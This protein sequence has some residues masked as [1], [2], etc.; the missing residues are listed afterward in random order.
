MTIDAPGSQFEHCAVGPPNDADSAH[1]TDEDDNGVNERTNA[2]T[3]AG[4]LVALLDDDA[5]FS[6][7]R[8]LVTIPSMLVHTLHHHASNHFI[9]NPSLF[10]YV[11][12]CYPKFSLVFVICSWG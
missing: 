9:T 7:F 12:Y 1:C 3:N 6:S 11:Q 5:I 8:N 10:C 4:K 2:A